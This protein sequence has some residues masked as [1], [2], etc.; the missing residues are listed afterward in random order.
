MAYDLH[1]EKNNGQPISEAE[2]NAVVLSTPDIRKGTGTV[3]AVNPSTGERIEIQM[4]PGSVEVCTRPAAGSECEWQPVFWYG[5]GR[6][7]FAATET[8][9]Q[10]PQDPIRRAAIALSTEIGARIVGDEGEVYAWGAP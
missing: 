1:I 9:M 5:R 3:T 7:S 8:L 4:Q 2:W 6:V 10:D